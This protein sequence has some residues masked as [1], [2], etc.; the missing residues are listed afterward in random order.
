MSL[1]K[2]KID[3]VRFRPGAACGAAI[4]AGLCILLSGGC[5]IDLGE[6]PFFCNQGKPECPDGYICHATAGKKICL[7][8]GSQPPK[9]DTGPPRPDGAPPDPD[10]KLPGDGP[11][12][13]KDT[14]GGTFPSIAITEFMANPKA[15]SDTDGEWLELFNT[16]GQAIDLNGW[17]LKDNDTDAHVISSPLVIPPKGYVI[18]GRTMDK[19]KNGG[20][21]VIYAYQQFY[22]ANSDD[23]VFL[24][25]T[26]GKIIDSFT[27]SKSKGFTVPEGG[28]LSV[29]SPGADKNKASSWCSENNPWPGSKGDRGTPGSNPG[30]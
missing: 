7:K 4:A 28:S 29:K 18:I 14:N 1:P 21:N 12:V 11:L 24:K 3:E 9:L 20:V 10:G 22:L 30:C 27:Y 23:E 25:N 6:S 16:T 19:A 2:R 8:E 15:V 13:K 26:S 17:T 5:T